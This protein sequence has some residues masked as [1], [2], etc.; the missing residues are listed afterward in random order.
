MYTVIQT[1]QEATPARNH[2]VDAGK[3]LV[4]QLALNAGLQQALIADYLVMPDH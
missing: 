1:T 3:A 4:S 2:T